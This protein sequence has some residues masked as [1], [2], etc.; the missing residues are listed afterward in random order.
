M[1]ALADRVRRVLAISSTVLWRLLHS[2]YFAWLWLAIETRIRL[3]PRRAERRPAR[4][5]AL[6][7]SWGFLPLVRTGIFRPAAFADV[8]ARLGVRVT[9]VCGAHAPELDG[10]ARLAALDA[11]V[12]VRRVRATVRGG[13]PVLAPAY[14]F[15]PG[16]DGGFAT[17]LLLARDAMRRVATPPDLVF[18]SGPRFANFVAAYFLARYWRAALQSELG[19]FHAHGGSCTPSPWLSSPP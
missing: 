9:V 2:L 1:T 14:R 16:I 18:A 19:F 4:R 3:A 8:W 5:E 10:A 15:F 17:A 6:V 13:E 7:V 11:N 12:L